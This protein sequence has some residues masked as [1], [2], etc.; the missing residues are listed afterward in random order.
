MVT[1]SSC[2]S[3]FAIEVIQGL[4]SSFLPR[5]TAREVLRRKKSG[6]LHEEFLGGVGMFEG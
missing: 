5:E 1:F 2:M 6:G 3:V 4:Q